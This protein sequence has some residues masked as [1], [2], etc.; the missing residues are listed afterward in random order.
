MQLIYSPVL[1]PGCC[2]ICR[3]AQRDS[4]IDTG[5]SLDYEGAFIIC[6][7][8]ITEMAHIMSF[9]SHDEY[10]DLR[11][12]KDE[13]ERINYELIKRVGALE[14]SLRA[15]AN[16][17]Y[18]SNDDGTVIVSGGYLPEV[19]E[20]EPKKPSRRKT[21]VGTGEGEVTESVHDS[22]MGELHSDESDTDSDFALEF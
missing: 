11:A 7:L 17:G 12:S 5:V 9:I 21:T 3:A 13:I 1:P 15:L 18:R 8:C 20:S 16:A 19:V 4:Y 10:K 6:N 2:F 14:E 22:G